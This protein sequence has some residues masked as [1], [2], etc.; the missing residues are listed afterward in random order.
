M[1]GIGEIGQ[2]GRFWPKLA[3]FDSFCPGMA[4]TGFFGEKSLFGPKTVKKLSCCPKNIHL[5]QFLQFQSW[6]FSD[7]SHKNSVFG[8]KKNGQKNVLPK[9]LNFPFLAPKRSKNCHFGPKKVISANFSKSSHRIFLIF[10]IE[11]QFRVL[12]KMAK[13]NSSRKI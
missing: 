1:T 13:I 7:F 6:D 2:N 10:L 11:T 12:K 4:K 5:D 8:L 3:I 9:N